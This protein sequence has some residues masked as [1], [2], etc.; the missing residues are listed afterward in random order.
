ME[1]GEHFL[2]TQH[3]RQMH[4]DLCKAYHHIFSK[5]CLLPSCLGCLH[6]RPPSLLSL[7]PAQYVLVSFS[8]IAS[9][10]GAF[11]SVERE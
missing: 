4:A 6:P 2:P 1:T 7:Y 5:K 11:N 3:P 8:Y 9:I 10:H